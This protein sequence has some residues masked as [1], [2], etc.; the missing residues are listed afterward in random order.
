MN[1]LYVQKF[2]EKILLSM[3]LFG[4]IYNFLMSINTCGINKIINLF[5]AASAL[6][7]IKRDYFLPFLGEAV[8]PNGVLETSQPKDANIG[9]VVNVP[10]STKVIYWAAESS[11]EIN[12]TPWKAYNKYSNSG[13]A[14]SDENGQA[15]LKFREPA[16]YMKPSMFGL[17]K[18]LQP[19]V[20][21]RYAKTNGMFSRVETIFI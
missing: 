20:H 15:T 9:V 5:I 16:V 14:I 11:D 19:H 17:E 6:M 13:V 1:K 8:I 18:Q 12:Q 7:V 10:P 2:K 4:A 21:F 3:L